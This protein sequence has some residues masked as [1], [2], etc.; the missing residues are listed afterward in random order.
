M[1][2]FRN[3][4]ASF[5]HLFCSILQGFCRVF[6]IEL[7]RY[8]KVS[9]ADGGEHTQMTESWR[10]KSFFG[11]SVVRS[12][13]FLTRRARRFAERRGE[14]EKIHRQAMASGSSFSPFN[15]SNIFNSSPPSIGPQNLSLL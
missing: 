11:S 14:A 2:C 7:Q 10:T 13:C 12:V 1:H 3:I 8:C 15:R 4:S 5:L 9:A 6:A